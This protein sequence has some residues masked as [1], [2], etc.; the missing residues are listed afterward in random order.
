[1][2]KLF[3]VVALCL[4][5][6]TTVHAQEENAV[7]L[8]FGD[9]VELLYQRDLDAKNFCSSRWHF[10]IST[11]FRLRESTTGSA[12]DGIGHPKRVTGI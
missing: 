8:R 3:L 11:V 1:M 2:K 4:C 5:L 6:F 12:V 10:R 9:G 7:G